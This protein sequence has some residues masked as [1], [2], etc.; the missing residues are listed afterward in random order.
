MAESLGFLLSDTARL[1]RRRF[2]ERARSS[3]ASVAQWRA[4]KIL[5]RHP[6][7]NQGQLADQLEVEPITACRMVDRLEEAGF[8]E[9]R[10]DPADR[11]AWRIHVTDKASPVL[12]ELQVL[13]EVMI[14]DMLRGLT[15]EQR[16]Q[17]TGS[18]QTVRDNLSNVQEGN[19]AANG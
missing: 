5:S 1:L 6:G 8:V 2:D 13:A 17:L 12:D 14:E 19:E 10:R 15:T 9:R 7:M 4:L 16:E 11:R 18:L 3:G